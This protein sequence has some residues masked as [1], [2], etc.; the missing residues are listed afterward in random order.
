LLDALDTAATR[1][2]EKRDAHLA[3]LAERGVRA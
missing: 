3:R 2:E 1:F